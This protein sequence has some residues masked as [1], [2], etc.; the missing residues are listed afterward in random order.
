M[1]KPM[2]TPGCE[3]LIERFHGKGHL[4]ALV[5]TMTDGRAGLRE[6]LQLIAARIVD[7]RVAAGDRHVAKGRA[8]SKDAGI[9]EI[10]RH[11]LA[12]LVQNLQE[13][14]EVAARM[15]MNRHIQLF[16]RRDAL[17]EQRRLA[18]L[19]LRGIENSLQAAVVRAVKFFDEVHRDFK[20]GTPFVG[21]LLVIVPALRVGKNIVAAKR[22]AEENSPA[23]LTDDSDVIVQRAGSAAGIQDRG[24]AVTQRAIER[25]FSP[26]GHR[27]RCRRFDFFFERRAEDEPIGR[28][29]IFLC[30]VSQQV[31]ADVKL[32]VNV[33][34]N[35]SGRNDFSGGVDDSVNR[36]RLIRADGFDA[37]AFDDH[38][39]IGDDFMA[40][41]GPTH[42]DAAV[43]ANLHVDFL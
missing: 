8:R 43:D 16:G 5:R 30:D 42:D 36:L 27:R 13:L 34:I 3:I 39:T 38:G 26:H 35:K 4:G 14:T 29:I 2:R 33:Q 22:R 28:Q 31:V 11:G 32:R 41:A 21:S 12:I 24:C 9:G 37:V 7:P 10:F 19:R 40:G 18:G 20:T 17:F 25:V 15:N 1:P 6:D 23:G